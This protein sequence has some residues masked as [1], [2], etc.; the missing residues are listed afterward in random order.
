MNVADYDPKL[1]KVAPLRNDCFNFCNIAFRC[2]LKIGCTWENIIK[3]VE[4]MLTKVKT[5]CFVACSLSLGPKFHKS[6]F[7]VKGVKWLL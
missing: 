2:L 6:I 3:N 4:I 5:H 7:Q 1:I